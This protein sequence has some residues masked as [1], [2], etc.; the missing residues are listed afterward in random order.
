MVEIFG[1][2]LFEVFEIEIL[3]VVCSLFVI[4][5]V[6]ALVYIIA[7]ILVIMIRGLCSRGLIVILIERTGEAFVMAG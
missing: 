7:W 3:M 5:E 1:Y 6:L 4:I 2:F